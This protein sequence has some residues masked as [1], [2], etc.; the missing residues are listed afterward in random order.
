MIAEIG[1]LTTYLTIGLT[2]IVYNYL[3]AKKM[4]KRHKET[5]ELVWKHIEEDR[6]RRKEV[7]APILTAEKYKDGRKTVTLR[8]PCYVTMLHEGDKLQI[9]QLTLNHEHSLTPEGQDVTFMLSE[10]KAIEK[11]L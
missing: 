10:N 4:L 5:H 6:K 8:V 2:P 1:L 9:L 11:R 3:M 7:H